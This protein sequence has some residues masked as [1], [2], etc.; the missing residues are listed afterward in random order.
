MNQHHVWQHLQRGFGVRKKKQT[1][2]VVYQSNQEPF[3][4]STRNYGAE[5]LFYS[6]GDDHSADES[7]TDFEDTAKSTVDTLRKVTPSVALDPDPISRLIS[8]LEVRTKFIREEL[9]KLSGEFMRATDVIFQDKKLFRRFLRKAW[10]DNPDMIGE[11]IAE[12][13]V[14]GLDKSALEEIA[15]SYVE[16]NFNAMADKA[17]M[18]I[19]AHT[20]KLRAA[21]AETGYRA[22]L[23]L[24]RETAS[25]EQRAE[26]Y[27][28][29]TYRIIEID[30]G[31]LI[32]PDTMVSFCIGSRV[33]PMLTGERAV[34]EVLLPLSST[35]L[36]YGFRKSFVPR[37]LETIN[38]ILA[39][40]SYRT[41]IADR[42]T[43]EFRQLTNRISRNATLVPSAEIRRV[44]RDAFE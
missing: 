32:L 16:Q 12:M 38:R 30:M 39:S 9:T 14:L 43:Q 19:I 37:P 31:S 42:D 29:L 35:R 36:L 44:L 13:P 7:I 25:P 33:A 26:N 8:H 10:M 23:K 28:D 40:C 6:E 17:R 18:D 27:L 4:T 20:P 15:N 24:L 1:Q 11:K 21:L 22:H 41:F 3:T 2:V 34:S 5:R